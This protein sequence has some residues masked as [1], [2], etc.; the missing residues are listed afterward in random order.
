MLSTLSLCM[1]A[2]AYDAYTDTQLQDAQTAHDCQYVATNRLLSAPA[3]RQLEQD[4]YVVLK[5][6]LTAEELKQVRLELQMQQQQRQRQQQASLSLSS[7]GRS[8]TSS[9][10]WFSERNHS[11]DRSVRT[12]AI[13]WV[14]C[15]A[16]AR[17]V[18]AD[19]ASNVSSPTTEP[20]PGGSMALQHCIHLIRGV[21]YALQQ[22][23]YQSY[24]SFRVPQ[25]CQLSQYR[26]NSQDQYHRHLD[27]CQHGILEM[28]VLA[29]WRAQDYRG[30]AVTAI[31]YLNA[32]DWQ[33]GGALR[34]F[35]KIPSPNHHDTPL[36][37][38]SQNADDIDNDNA[39]NNK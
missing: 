12:D 23:D 22:H 11:N 8:S 26:G 20:E 19:A 35:H 16:D 39:S 6:A 31:L 25:Q 30:H 9:S 1:V 15:S 38:L 4:G 29:Y 14:R 37:S 32:P 27:Q 5:N 24:T 34:C 13:C 7:S 2:Y 17:A 33:H 10:S 18:A 28:G 3:V 21:P 36:S